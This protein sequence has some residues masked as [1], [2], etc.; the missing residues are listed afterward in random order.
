MMI[1]FAIISSIVAFCLIFRA[2][3][4]AIT[5]F[6]SRNLKKMLLRL[7]ILISVL[8]ICG[9]IAVDA[10][11]IAISQNAY[12]E[13]PQ[14]DQD[15]PEDASSEDG[16]SISNENDVF[17]PDIPIPIP[18]ADELFPDYWTHEFFT[19]IVGMNIT[20]LTT[21]DKF[22]GLSK[23][24]EKVLVKYKNNRNTTML[25]TG[26][27][28]NVPEMSRELKNGLEKFNGD[29]A[30]Y[31]QDRK[32]HNCTLKALDCLF[33]CEHIYNK[34]EDDSS[35]RL[36]IYF[37]YINISLW[38]LINEYVTDDLSEEE[39]CDLYYRLAQT[40][41]YA[42]YLFN[43]NSEYAKSAEGEQLREA[44]RLPFVYAATI[45]YYLSYLKSDTEG[46]SGSIYSESVI[47]SYPR[48]LNS[49]A[50]L[51]HIS[52]RNDYLKRVEEFIKDE[53]EL[54]LSATIISEL[55]DLLENAEEW[56][57]GENDN[58]QNKE[59]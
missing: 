8:L 19:I 46:F 33:Y 11:Y 15:F 59:N 29:L 24:L 30:D 38:G 28:Q 23:E 43:Y 52:I 27:V 42:N 22:E 47:T 4:R 21:I 58:E 5:A 44:D 16:D 13:Q 18:R 34:W 53:K 6:K 31:Y 17:E 32:Y 7:V 37:Y 56:E 35:H 49:L 54:N 12:F 14:P 1:V 51:M 10:I 40:L 2:G 20:A 45:C 48:A 26:Y 50:L 36:Q 25:P 39:L 3:R 41:E 9:G 55:D 57:I